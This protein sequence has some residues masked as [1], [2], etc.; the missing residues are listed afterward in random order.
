MNLVKT[1]VPVGDFCNCGSAAMAWICPSVCPTH[2]DKR[3]TVGVTQLA[4]EFAL[5]QAPDLCPLAVGS[6][7]RQQAAVG[8]QG[9]WR[10]DPGDPR[11]FTKLDPAVGIHALDPSALVNQ[12]H[13]LRIGRLG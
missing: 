7:C 4:E 6:S 12:Q 2:W 8:A 9:V 13:G 11:D 10:G 3:L 1:F 5:H